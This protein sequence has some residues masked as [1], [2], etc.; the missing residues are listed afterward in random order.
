M[1]QEV[2]I[3]YKN[4]LTE[5]EYMK[6]KQIYFKDEAI[7]VTQENYYFD[8]EDHVL[9]RNQCALRIRTKENHAEMTLKTPFEGHHTETTI[10][11][12]PESAKKMIITGSFILPGDIISVLKDQNISIDPNVFIVAD[13]KT[14]RLEI[15]NPHSI[16]VL[17][18]S[19][20]SDQ[21]DFELEI[22]SASKVTGEV[23]F[24]QIL[25]D[26]AIPVRPTINKIAR[27]F[28]AKFKS[29]K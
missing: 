7:P 27:A 21:Q 2:E 4:L 19:Y 17:D 11:L 25:K 14:E 8:S 22:E 18:K 29:D 5:E 10:D 12:D 6:I 16:I 13:L 3:E 15:I 9:K 28:K 1:K 26:N 24:N 23:L 20:Y